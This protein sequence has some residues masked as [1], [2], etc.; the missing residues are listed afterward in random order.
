M[1]QGIESLSGYRE[2]DHTADW[3]LKAWSMDLPGLFREAASGMYALMGVQFG[4]SLSNPRRL[5]LSAPDPESLLVGFL[6]ELLYFVEEG[7]G[8]P[9]IT[10]ALEGFNLDATMRSSMIL[11]GSKEIKAVTFHN[12]RIE[13]AENRCETTIVFDV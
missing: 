6:S 5:E 3:A 13:R 11:E 12:L 7:V 10:V 9:E 1:D 2:I 8:F 4:E